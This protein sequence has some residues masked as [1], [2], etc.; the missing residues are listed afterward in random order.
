MKVI[1]ILNKIA[2]G[3]EVPYRI[4]Y[5]GKIYEYVEEM[6]WYL[7][8][9]MKCELSNS[10]KCLNDEVEVIDDEVKEDNDSITWWSNRFKVVE[11]D[12]IR[13]NN[14]INE[15]E[16]YIKPFLYML[17]GITDKDEYEQAQLDTFTDIMEKL[18]EL[19]GSDK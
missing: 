8:D 9:D 12:N 7:R 5:I 19:K 6:K 2:N 11:R 18:Q 16:E 3:E 15:L 1:D 17:N 13:L 14:I 4:K 10:K